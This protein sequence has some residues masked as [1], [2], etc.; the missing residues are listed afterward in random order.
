M[1]ESISFTHV[2]RESNEAT[3]SMAKEGSRFQDIRF[4]MEETP[5]T[6]ERVV[7]EDRL[8]LSQDRS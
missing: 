1:S 4:W 3:H 6:V 7:E 5:T 8:K 2:K